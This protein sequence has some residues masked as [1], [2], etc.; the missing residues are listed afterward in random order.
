MNA[1]GCKIEEE[2]RQRG[3][4]SFASFMESALYASGLGY[5]EQNREIG[6]DGDFFTSVSVGPLFG[7]LLAF[8]FAQWMDKDV[9]ECDILLIEAGPHNGALAADILDWISRYRPDLFER[10]EYCL[11]DGSPARRGWQEEKL[12]PWLPKVS[13]VPG[14][15]ALS[16]KEITGIIFSN[17]FLDALPVHL[18]AWNAAR[19]LWQEGFVVMR[20]ESFA[21]EWQSPSLELGP[22]LPEVP[23]ALKSVLPEGFRVEICPA[24]VAWWRCAASR[25]RRGKLMAIDY[26]LLAEE[27]LQPERAKGTL[28]AF[29]RHHVAG[30]VLSQPGEQDLTAHVNFSAL[31]DAGQAAG[32]RTTHFVRQSKFLTEILAQAR[33]EPDAFAPWD[34][35]RTRQFQTLTHPEHLGH[36]FRV[37]VQ[38][39]Q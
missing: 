10:V 1:L 39:R 29:V 25:L 38:T 24:S 8:Q 18:L 6:R 37:L 28:R 2:I 3:A 36:K 20:N 16:G 26:G 14:L 27:R 13:W 35:R 22:H 21:L 11:L 5:Y 30:D 23:S 15:Q 7:Q 32:L 31:I 33:S 34:E 9:P 12:R 4:I 19:Q 17:E